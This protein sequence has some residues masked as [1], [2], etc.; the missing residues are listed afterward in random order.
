[1]HMYSSQYDAMQ[2]YVETLSYKTI[3]ISLKEDSFTAYEQIQN[4]IG[5]YEDVRRQCTKLQKLSSAATHSS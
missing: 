5:F 1:M 3:H 2:S 4:Y